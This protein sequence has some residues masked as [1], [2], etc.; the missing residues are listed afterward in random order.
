MKIK[1]LILVVICTLSS[2]ALAKK[3]DF[4]VAGDIGQIAIPAFA[5]IMTY[6]KDDKE[7]SIQLLK[8]Y[9]A[10]MGVTYA[11]KYAFDSKR[12]NGGKRGFPSAHT[13]SAFAGAAFLGRRYGW[14]YGVPAYIGASL[15]AASAVDARKN[16]VLDVVGS[17]AIS[18]ILNKLFT[19]PLNDNLNV[20]YTVT[21]E[22]GQ[23][24]L[25]AKF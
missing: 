16:K 22:S 17:A 3:R 21:P 10:T 18:L 14:E 15:V 23:L 12:P 13:T 2:N 9:G 11:L 7:G 20:G 24:S 6:Y 8:L 5:G 4:T 19:T 25:D 1:L